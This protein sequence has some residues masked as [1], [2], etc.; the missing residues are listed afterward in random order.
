MAVATSKF[1]SKQPE[2]ATDYGKMLSSDESHIPHGW[3]AKIGQQPHR[4]VDL[5][6]EVLTDDAQSNLRTLFSN[7]PTLNKISS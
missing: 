2:L 4:L 3:T 7:T 5:F 1:L 6:T